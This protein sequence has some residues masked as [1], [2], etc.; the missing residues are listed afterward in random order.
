MKCVDDLLSE[1]K[2]LKS[3]PI[4]FFSLI[5]GPLLHK[6]GFHFVNVLPINPKIKLDFIIFFCYVQSNVMGPDGLQR[7]E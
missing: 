6:Y 4:S 3:Y 5:R 2:F 1:L 7:N